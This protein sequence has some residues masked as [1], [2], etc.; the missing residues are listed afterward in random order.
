MD[1]Q[2]L[3][4]DS[5][6]L[7]APAPTRDDIR[8]PR[9][10]R[11]RFDR[12]RKKR[13]WGRWLVGGFFLLSFVS[14]ALDDEKDTE[15]QAP[16]QP[17]AALPDNPVVSG[18]LLRVQAVCRARD[19]AISEDSGLVPMDEILRFEL[20]TTSLIEAVPYPREAAG[21]RRILVQGRRKVDRVTLATYRGMAASPTPTRTFYEEYQSLVSRTVS[22]MYSTFA[23][24]GVDCQTADG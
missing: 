15:A 19:R 5:S 14:A 10:P 13:H 12:W 22:E 11:R 18:Y 20:E 9:P 4:L 23:G 21:L 7:K 24:I 2:G 3:Q 17:V 8:N 6:D 16:A 1:R